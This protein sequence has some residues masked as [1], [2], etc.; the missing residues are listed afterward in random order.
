MTRILGGRMR[1]RSVQAEETVN[2]GKTT[3]A[4]SQR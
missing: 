1:K 3:E 2:T 4:S